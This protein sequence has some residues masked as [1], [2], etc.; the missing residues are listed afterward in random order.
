MIACRRQCVPSEINYPFSVSIQYQYFTV[1]TL[2]YSYYYFYL[3]WDHNDSKCSCLD[4]YSLGSF[5][6]GKSFKET[7][8]YIESQNPEYVLKI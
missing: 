6:A 1:F 8:G 7:G 5:C 2:V 4:W 3:P